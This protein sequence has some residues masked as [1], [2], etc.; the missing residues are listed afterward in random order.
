MLNVKHSSHKTL[1]Q[2]LSCLIQNCLF[3]SVIRTLA[4]QTRKNLPIN[5]A[6]SSL[7]SSTTVVRAV[8]ST[9]CLA[10]LENV[11]WMPRIFSS[12]QELSMV[13]LKRQSPTQ[14]GSK[15]RILVP[16]STSAVLIFFLQNLLFLMEYSKREKRKNFTTLFASSSSKFGR[17]RERPVQNVVTFLNPTK[18]RLRGVLFCTS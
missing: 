5:S 18:L 3:S 11:L 2:I 12:L 14:Q 4:V 15:P 6:S 13:I 17:P 1:T 7:T 10:I 8:P 9:L 16:R